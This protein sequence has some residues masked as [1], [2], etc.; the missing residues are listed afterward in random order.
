MTTANLHTPERQ[1]G[2]SQQEYRSRRKTSH[3]VAQRIA[4][5]HM[6]AHHFE[7][8]GYRA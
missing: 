8:R 1:P 5:F 2:E 3:R 7:W 4:G 6:S